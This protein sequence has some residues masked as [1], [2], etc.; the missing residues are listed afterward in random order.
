MAIPATPKRTRAELAHIHQVLPDIPGWP[1]SPEEW[2]L[3]EHHL[4]ELRGAFDDG[5]LDRIHRAFAI[6]SGFSG[7]FRGPNTSFNDA[8][9]G[10]V[11]SVPQIIVDLVEE[12]TEKV[13]SAKRDGLNQADARSRN[14]RTEAE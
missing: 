4:I 10:P 12:L 2:S 5:D 1:V 8:P 14:D 6:I 3:M 9:S 11:K 13:A 7:G